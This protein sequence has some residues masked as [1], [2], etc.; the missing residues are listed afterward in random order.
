MVSMYLQHPFRLNVEES[1]LENRERDVT[2]KP[3][4][5][6]QCQYQCKELLSEITYVHTIT[7][8]IKN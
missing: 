7:N 6:Y 1:F 2:R 4:G 3:E 5:I 8:L